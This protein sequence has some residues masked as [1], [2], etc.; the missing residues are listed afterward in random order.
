MLY[1]GISKERLQRLKLKAKRIWRDGK[2]INYKSL[3]MQF[4]TKSM[5]VLFYNCKISYRLAVIINTL[6]CSIYNAMLYVYDG[7][8]SRSVYWGGI[9]YIQGWKQDFQK[10]GGVVRKS[11]L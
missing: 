9:Y 4:D 1:Q 11:E 3:A 5:T 6:S 7:P 10:G 2:E 8:S